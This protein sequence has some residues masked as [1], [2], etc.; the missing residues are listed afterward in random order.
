MQ[1]ITL[2]KGLLSKIIPLIPS[3]VYSH[4]M[5]IITDNTVKKLY[6]N[7]VINAFAARG[8]IVDL[9]A[10]PPGEKSKT[11][12]MKEKIETRLLK[13]GCD[14][15]TCLL[16]LGGGV[17][18]DLAGFVAATYMRG[19][20]YIQIPTTTLAMIDSSLGG[21]TGINTPEG[22]NLIGAFWEPAAVIADLDC[23][24]SLPEKH[25]INGWVEALKIFLISDG[26]LFI[27]AAKNGGPNQELIRRAIELKSSIVK[28]DPREKN[29]R[30]IL[31]YGHTIGHALEKASDYTL[32]HGT[33]V[34]L[35]I[36]I[37][38][39]ISHQRG[40]LKKDDLC[41]IQGAFH[42]LKIQP[43]LLDA[44]HFRSLLKA[45]QS[46]KKNMQSAIHGVLLRGLGTVFTAQGIYTHPLSEEE[47]KQAFDAVRGG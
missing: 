24:D 5:V 13:M 36:Q 12:E 45:M 4:R 18:G 28:K 35:G 29:L 33:A 15:H 32:L 8:K 16:A 38:S 6:A 11:R 2:G 27:K 20:P 31:N 47:I 7:T 46:D 37:E 1:T 14:R 44:F 17:V 22:K 30:A 39:Q 23:L 19:I 34:G 21:K 9:I 25:R 42:D 3:E 10:F 41:L 40:L 26:S 43:N